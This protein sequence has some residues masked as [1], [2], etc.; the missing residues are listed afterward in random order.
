MWLKI[1][2][3]MVWLRSG[4]VTMG[5]PADLDFYVNAAVEVLLEVF[6]ACVD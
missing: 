2:R 6:E 4:T 5:D 3:S 1:V